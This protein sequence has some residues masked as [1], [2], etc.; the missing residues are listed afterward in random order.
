MNIIIA[1]FA[2]IIILLTAIFAGN[3]YFKNK[4]LESLRQNLRLKLMY[5]EDAIDRLI[6][7]ERKMRPE[8]TK[9]SHYEAAISKWERHNK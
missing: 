8:G 3:M 2:L 6:D 7:Q 4:K 9:I 5:N 1:A